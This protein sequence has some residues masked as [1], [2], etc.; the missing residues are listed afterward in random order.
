MH[1]DFFWLLRRKQK[2]F[3]GSVLKI[4]F[5]RQHLNFFFQRNSQKISVGNILITFIPSLRKML[6]DN[7]G[8]HSAAINKSLASNR[9][10]CATDVAV[11]ECCNVSQCVAVLQIAT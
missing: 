2:I 5:C 1:F 3:V 11:A 8:L 4:F 6:F 9:Q 7:G 10:Q